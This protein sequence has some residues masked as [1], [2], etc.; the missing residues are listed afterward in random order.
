VKSCPVAIGLQAGERE[1]G[2]ECRGL[3]VHAV[4]PPDRRYLG[5]L[6]G[7]ALQN[8]DEAVDRLDEKARASHEARRQGCVG[9]VRGGQ[10]VVDP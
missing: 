10:A 1:L 6:E 3:G 8:R 7:A 5:E 2:A 9:H 4:R